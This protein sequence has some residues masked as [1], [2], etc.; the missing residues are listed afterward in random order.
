M[1]PINT[2]PKRTGVP[3]NVRLTLKSGHGLVGLLCANSGHR[4][5]SVLRR[6]N[7]TSGSIPIIGTKQ[8]HTSIL[9]PRLVLSVGILASESAVLVGGIR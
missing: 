6:L 8:A 3:A 7:A 2:A 4:G 9:Y 5:S 1:A